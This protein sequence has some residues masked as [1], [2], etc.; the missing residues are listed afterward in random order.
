M[1]HHDTASDV[2]PDSGPEP[3]DS[4]SAASSPA[5]KPSAAPAPESAQAIVEGHSHG[6]VERGNSGADAPAPSNWV[7]PAGP[8]ADS[9][10]MNEIATPGTGALTPTGTHDDGGSTS[11]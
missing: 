5:H 8:H 2:T 4:N 9:K 1:T 10:L 6:T 3:A 11:S 7:P